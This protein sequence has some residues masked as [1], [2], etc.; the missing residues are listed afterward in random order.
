MIASAIPG[1]GKS[2]SALNL[3]ASL[4]QNGGNVLLVDADLRRGTLSKILGQHSEIGLSEEL[5]GSADRNTYLEVDEVPGL[6]FL[7]AGA[8]Q[9]ASSELLGS[10]KLARMIQ[11]WR[12][13]FSHV[14]IDTPALLPVSDAVIVSPYVDMAILVARSAFTQR[15]A[16]ARAI[17]VLRGAQVK[18]IGLLVNGMDPQSSEYG[19]YYGSYGYEE[20]RNKG[21]RPLAKRSAANR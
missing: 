20:S 2:F 5:L 12:G 4:A 17:S 7:P 3:A 11:G 1:E 9:S 21:P 14:V 13:A 6:S 16:I 15:Q 10:K 8:L 19:H 18:S